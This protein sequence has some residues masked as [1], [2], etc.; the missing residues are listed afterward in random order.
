VRCSRLAAVSPSWRR[1]V[2]RHAV[3]WCPVLGGLMLLCTTGEWISLEFAMS[4]PGTVTEEV[5]TMGALVAVDASDAAAL[6][7]YA[8]IEG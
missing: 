3:V 7:S 4:E 6:L 2:A 5:V 1:P 8:G